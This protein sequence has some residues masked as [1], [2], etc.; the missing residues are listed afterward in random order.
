MSLTK[1][2]NMLYIVLTTDLMVL[3]AILSIIGT[4]HYIAFKTEK[5]EVIVSKAP[6]A[7]E[8]S[9]EADKNKE[10]KVE[11][12]V[13]NVNQ[14]EETVQSKEVAEPVKEIVYEGLTMEELSA[15][16]D[17]SLSSTLSGYGSTF[18]NY[19]VQLG[20]DPYLAVAIVLHE[21]GCKW[22]CSG[23]VQSC[24]NIGGQ[25]GSGCNGYQY[26]NSL[27][28]GIKGYMDNLYY[29][30]YSQGLTTPELMNPKYAESTTWAERVNN[31]IYEIKAS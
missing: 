12:S 17:R 22:G 11:P 31:Y 26:F 13:E 1:K 9:L 8:F 21:T 27:E 23:L 10:K 19:A 3:I 18:A 2:K 29:N 20:M 7:A 16:L 25:K 14:I 24:N 6:K 15:K 5:P 4:N 28:E 30:Y